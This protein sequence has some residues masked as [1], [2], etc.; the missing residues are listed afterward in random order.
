MATCGA[1]MTASGASPCQ[2][3]D[4]KEFMQDTTRGIVRVFPSTQGSPLIQFSDRSPGSP[5]ITRACFKWQ[6]ALGCAAGMSWSGFRPS[7]DGS[8]FGYNVPGVPLTPSTGS[9]KEPSMPSSEFQ[10][11]PGLGHALLP[12]PIYISSVC[13]CRTE[14]P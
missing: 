7:D 8:R 1:R 13:C 11:V 10:D 5:A 9:L 12:S 3:P 2:L 6:T 4:R 14:A